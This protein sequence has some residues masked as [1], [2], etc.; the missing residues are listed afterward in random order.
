MSAAVSRIADLAAAKVDDGDVVLTYA[1]SSTVNRAL[2]RAAEAGKSF[3][4][5][6]ADARP[7]LE[8]RASLEQLVEAGIPCT[9]V[10]LNAANYMMAS[11]T[12]VLLGAAAM[13][14]NGSM[15]GR[16]GSVRARPRPAARAHTSGV[17]TR[18]AGRPRP[19]RLWRRWSQ[20][21]TASPCLC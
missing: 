16:V 7:H 12:K 20:T 15:Q 10:S 1:R 5:V 19:C 8:G 6:V 13:F 11:V 4:V 14:S 18:R 17:T 9:Y 2:V 21:R 3:R